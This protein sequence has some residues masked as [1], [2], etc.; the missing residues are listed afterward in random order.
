MAASCC[1]K[2]T[3]SGS[4][5]RD[6]R[7]S[8]T[9][10][11]SGRQPLPTIA[12]LPWSASRPATR[13]RMRP[14]LEDDPQLLG[15]IYA[16]PYQVLEPDLAFVVDG[17]GR[18]LAATCSA[19]RTRARSMPGWR[20]NGIRACSGGW[21]TPDPTARLARQRLGAAPD[22]SSRSRAFPQALA[23]YPVARPYRSFARGARQGASAG[24][25]WRSSRGG[26]PPPVRPGFFMQLDPRNEGALRFYEAIGFEMLRDADLPAAFRLCRQAVLTSRIAHCRLQR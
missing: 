18:R 16:I 1:P 8:A 5:R 25:R 14:Q 12:A 6:P 11:S 2:A 24:E 19:R 10:F 9:G 20:R 4:C 15:L 21:P 7:L 23:A 3:T 13:A 22:S 26:L 17:P